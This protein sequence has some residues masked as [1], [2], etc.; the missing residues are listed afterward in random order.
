MKLLCLYLAFINIASLTA[1]GID[2]YRA[3]RHRWR[4]PERNL[5]FMAALGGSLG[6]LLGMWIFRHKTRSRLFSV[7]LPVM[8]SAHLL[9]LLLIRPLL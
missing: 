3:C 6:A 2:K 9:L 5:F 1:M 4:I 7:G 8:L